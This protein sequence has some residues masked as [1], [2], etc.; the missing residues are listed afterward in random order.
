MSWITEVINVLTIAATGA[1]LGYFFNKKLENVK[2]EAALYLMKYQTLN[3]KRVEAIEEI[4]TK[5]EKAICQAPN[6]INN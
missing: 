6:I 1:L 5:L 2:K 4:Y 3:V